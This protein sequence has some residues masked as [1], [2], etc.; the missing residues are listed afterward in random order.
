MTLETVELQPDGGS[1][2]TVIWL[3][4][5]GADG[6]DFEPIVPMLELDVAV[7]F[8]FPHAPVRPVTINGG[9]E[10]RAWYDIDPRSPLSGSDD[11]RASGDAVEELV[12][13]EEG[14]GVPRSRIVLAGFSQGGVVALHLALRS[15]T[16]FAGVMALSTYVHDHENL[17]DLISFASI[18]TPIFIAHGH[19]DPMIPI[20]RAITSR[21]AL[22]G[23]GYDVEW[24]EYGMGHEVCPQEIADIARWLDANLA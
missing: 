3:H 1:A 9:M 20:T 18:D 14:R 6:H 13:A 22:V 23:L 4:G 11:I 5:L 7:R 10:M 15:E 24:H 19:M 17:A 12:L 2:G 21:E 16:R 8:V